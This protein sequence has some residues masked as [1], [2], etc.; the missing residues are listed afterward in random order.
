[1]F[2]F[3]HSYVPYV[4]NILEVSTYVEFNHTLLH[5]SVHSKNVAGFQFHPE[6]SGEEGLKL[7]KET[8]VKIKKNRKIP[9]KNN[10]CIYYYKKK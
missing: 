6:K 3:V 8:I 9:N 4:K 1:M 7:L 5:S 2:Y 10:S